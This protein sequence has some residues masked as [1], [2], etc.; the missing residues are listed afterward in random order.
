MSK[1]AAK[2]SH[3]AIMTED[4]TGTI[5]DLKRQWA[6]VGINTWTSIHYAPKEGSGYISGEFVDIYSGLTMLSEDIDMDVIQYRDQENACWFARGFNQKRGNAIEHI[7]WAVPNY[8][9]MIEKMKEAGYYSLSAAADGEKRWVQLR[10]LW[11]PGGFGIELLEEGMHDHIAEQLDNE[12]A[13]KGPDPKQ[14]RFAEIGCIVKDRDE[15]V[16][17]LAPAFDLLGI[18]GFQCFDLP[19]N[20]EEMLNGKPFTM[21]MGQVF[22]AE[23]IELLIHE[24]VEG[25]GILTE[26]LKAKGEGIA[27]IGFRVKNYDKAVSDIQKQGYQMRES[28]KCRTHGIRWSYFDTGFTKSGVILKIIEMEEETEHV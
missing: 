22:L 16:K 19:L 6:P 25:E 21:K 17:G 1:D 7:A 27:Y 9:E 14:Y 15:A 24:P 10:N 18:G 2:L 26:Y 20:A 4:F 23:G 8:D 28:S 5:Q 12:Q 3:V 13:R 11:M